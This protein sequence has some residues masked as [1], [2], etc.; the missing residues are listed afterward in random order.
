MNLQNNASEKI[1]A[2][3]CS[4]KYLKGFVFHSPKYRDPTEIEVG[5]VVLWIRDIL[6]VFEIIW[7]NPIASTN[8]TSFIK[9]IGRKRDQIIQDYQIYKDGSK[10]IEMV[11]ENSEQILYEHNF[12]NKRG[13]CGI[14]IVDSDIHLENLHYQTIKKTLEQEFPI[15]IMRKQDFLDIIVE[16]DTASD[17]GYYLHD[18]KRFIQTIFDEDTKLFLD[19]NRRTER[20]LMSFYKLNQ[21]SFPLDSWQLNHDKNFWPAYS[22]NYAEQI[23]RRDKENEI[24][25]SLDKLIDHLRNL[26]IKDG[27]ALQHCWELAILPRRSRAGIMTE[28]IIDG[29]EKMKQG[30]EKRH[31]AFA[32]LVT[33]CH[34]LFFFRYGSDRET[35]IEEAKFLTK[36][37]IQVEIFEN[38][39]QYSVFCFAFRKSSLH[40]GNDWDDC[41]L[42]VED[43]ENHTT[44]SKEEY[45]NAKKH[46]DGVTRIDLVHEFPS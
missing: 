18:R 4:Q 19:L 28:K 2:F 7:R 30:K 20:T 14:V 37:K 34:D 9:K 41:V 17:L 45:Q 6:I 5:D 46:F 8:T 26:Q 11:N 38:N 10:Q 1:F 22:Q 16:A 35:F 21:N 24:S 40:T 25:Q 27:S 23:R 29:F 36:M 3:L 33:G 42:W 39:F 12:F 32:N 15:A 31:F 13:F 43:A 44:V